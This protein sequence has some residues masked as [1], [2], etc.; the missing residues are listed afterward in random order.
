MEL[1]LRLG[2]ILLASVLLSA[3]L[4]RAKK[5]SEK[6]HPARQ[7][8]EKVKPKLV[9]D[10]DCQPFK[11]LFFK[12]HHIEKHP[13]VLPQA[14]SLLLSF[15]SESL[16]SELRTER[17]I[18]SVNSFSASVLEEFVRKELDS[19][20]KEWDTYLRGR[21][22]GQPRELFQSAAEGRRWLVQKAPLKFVD[23]AWLGHVHKATTPFAL[24]RVT[25]AAWQVLSEELGDGDLEK[26]HT[27]VYAK[28]LEKIA[29]PVPPP[30]SVEFTQHSGMDDIGVWR[31]ALAQ[32][33]ISLFPHEFLP[34]ILGF[35]LH[36]ELMTLE[37]L[38]TAKELREVGID[39]YY[40]TL[41]ITIDNA[42]SGHTAMASRIVTDYLHLVSEM[43]GHAVAQREWKRVQAGYVLS[44]NIGQAPKEALSVEVLD[45][46]RAKSIA[47]NR[48]H[49]HCP[50]KFGGR[51]LSSWL[52]PASFRRE[53]WQL[54]FLRCLGNARP[55]VYKGNSGRSR[56]MHQFSWGGSMFGAFTD[57]EVAT[58]RD[59][60]N[61]LSP[62]G[63]EVYTEFTGRDDINKN[64]QRDAIIS[65]FS[66]FS[67]S[68]R[69]PIS[70]E[71]NSPHHAERIDVDMSK[72]DTKKLLPLW[73]AHTSLLE[74]FVSVPWNVAN[75]AG[76]AIIRLLR[77]QY[78]FLPEPIGVDGLDE[79]SRTDHIDLLSIGIEILTNVQAG[80]ALPGRLSEVL[81]QWPSEFAE[82]MLA[83]AAK[84]REYEWTLLGLASAF[85][86]LHDIIASSP[87]LLST[88]TRAALGLIREREHESL[89]SCVDCL[90]QGS[91]EDLSF[92]KGL[93]L[94]LREIETCFR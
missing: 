41:H 78:G 71:G 32:L 16:Q 68:S 44:K 83:A 62:P 47:S 93:Q 15:F 12:L 60:I 34:E 53:E 3:F 88:S 64:T 20:G 86:Q 54:E 43:H 52:D 58:V 49:D 84:P 1:L 46:F 45:I 35:N 66:A 14:K 91:P 10:L 70:S 65:A 50:M 18:I 63:P 92:R 48:I 37:T 57:R 9:K 42:D 61:S 7:V 76:C 11:E 85:T 82:A 2:P 27:Y 31:A 89:S 25:K 38:V 74:S 55:W 81:A 26:C 23:G 8:D 72:L 29:S 22:A 33:L 75:P 51:S 13:N 87:A 28:L 6:K 5:V 56:L 4:V 19:V 73:F 79:M 40:F 69:D 94:G 67:G 30:D 36:F 59:W 80:H 77:A 39:P 17:S 24:R 21:K 90:R